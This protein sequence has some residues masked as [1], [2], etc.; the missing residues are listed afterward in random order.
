LRIGRL[1]DARSLA[2]AAMSRAQR[3]QAAHLEF[4]AMILRAQCDMREDQ[5]QR[6]QAD[7]MLALER[8][9]AEGLREQE[10]RV[11]SAL[12]DVHTRIGDL[13]AARD[14]FAAAM[15]IDDH[16]GNREDQLTEMLNLAFIAV[17]A[18]EPTEARRLATAVS[19]QLLATPHHFHECALVDV[20]A[21]LAGLELDWRASMRW[22]LAATR[23]FAEG[24]YVES[25]ERRRRRESDLHQARAALAPAEQED[26]ARQAEVA[27][28]VQELE[29]VRDWLGLVRPDGLCDGLPQE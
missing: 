21:C 29:R 24:G 5:Q 1:G 9:R 20:C 14:C 26:I 11:L 27:T 16:Q 23:H 10:S 25:P 3:A 22:H 12:G 19:R 18:G 28:L 2:L 7:L 8:A 15:T 13:A 6:A 4:G 17:R